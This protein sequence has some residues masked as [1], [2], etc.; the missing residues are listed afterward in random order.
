LVW[1]CL[2]IVYHGPACAGRRFLVGLDPVTTAYHAAD[3][4]WILGQN[5]IT[6]HYRRG[7]GQ[8][9]DLSMGEVVRWLGSRAG[10]I[11]VDNVENRENHQ[12]W[13]HGG[14]SVSKRKIFSRLVT[15]A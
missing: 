12:E 4:A 1:V 9:I 10:V 3:L 2:T 11:A 8:G 15:V 14:W 5:T 7:Q 13:W 6:N